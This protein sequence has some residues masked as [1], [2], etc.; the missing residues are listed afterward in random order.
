MK[1]RPAVVTK[2][3]GLLFIVGMLLGEKAAGILANILAL[4]G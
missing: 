1:V 3:D 2:R 4:I